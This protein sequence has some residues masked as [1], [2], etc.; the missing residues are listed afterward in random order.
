[1]NQQKTFAKAST[2]VRGR[3][4]F[5]SAP[6]A[7]ACFT[8]TLSSTSFSRE[9]LI[10]QTG[11]TEVM[12]AF[13]LN[14]DSK[15]E[16]ILSILRKDNLEHDFPFKLETL[17]VSGSGIRF[18]SDAPPAASKYVEVILHLGE[19]F[20]MVGAIGKIETEAAP[21]DRNSLD[22]AYDPANRP[23]TLNFTRISEPDLDTIVQFVF[24]EERRKIREYRWS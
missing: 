17:E 1:M 8:S 3:L 24:Q 6:N 15:L 21:A 18:T 9:E 4:R 7:P 22:Q 13:L 20:G 12:V 16:S 2:F 14:L 19:S 11:M 5:L 23:R 10:R